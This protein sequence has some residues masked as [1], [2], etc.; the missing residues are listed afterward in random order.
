MA[1]NFVSL[2]MYLWSCCMSSQCDAFVSVVPECM[3]VHAAMHYGI[4]DKSMG[5]IQ[6]IMAKCWDQHLYSMNLYVLY[7]SVF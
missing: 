6:Q 1:C 5:N 4:P 3:G 7:I 2:Y